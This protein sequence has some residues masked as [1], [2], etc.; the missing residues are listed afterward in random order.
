MLFQ[1]IDKIKK[2]NKNKKL[3]KIILLW[4]I[5]IGFFSNIVFAAKILP[6]AEDESLDYYNEYKF[7]KSTCN[8]GSIFSSDKAQAVGIVEVS[9][10]HFSERISSP[11]VDYF[12]NR[13]THC[14]K[15]E[16]NFYVLE[17]VDTQRASSLNQTLLY[18][19]KINKKLK[20]CR[21]VPTNYFSVYLESDKNNFILIEN[22]IYIKGKY[23]NKNEFDSYDFNVS[24]SI[25]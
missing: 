12:Q 20:E 9:D 2:M 5:L 16:S 1:K 10:Y 7:N 19:C 23:K 25:F 3:R 14:I 11:N 22:Q 17:Q 21:F 8:V 24:I 18:V 6:L 15:S 4:L 13:F